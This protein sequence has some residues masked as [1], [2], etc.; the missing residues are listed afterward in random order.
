M[1]E[2]DRPS[3]VARGNWRVPKPSELEAK[4]KELLFQIPA[5]P[6][7]EFVDLD[8]PVHFLHS[9]VMPI[10]TVENGMMTPHGSGFVLCDFEYHALIVTARHVIE[11]VMNHIRL[12][13]HRRPELNDRGNLIVDG[14]V[15][16]ALFIGQHTVGDESGTVGIALPAVEVAFSVRA[17]VAALMVRVPKIK[18]KSLQ[19]AVIPLSPGVPT[20]GAEV[21]GVG[22]TGITTAIKETEGDQT[23]VDFDRRFHA[24][25]GKVQAV[26]PEGR[27]RYMLPF[28]SLQVDARFDSGMSGGPVILT[29]ASG[30][31]GIVTSSLNRMHEDQ[32]WTSF[33]GLLGPLFDLQF[34]FGEG[35]G[36]GKLTIWDLML[37]GSVKVD[38]GIASLEATETPEG[39]VVNYV[40]D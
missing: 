34:S 33:V 37:R 2:P 4:S 21:M 30:I 36:G 38:D 24:T 14:I 16:H 5:G 35:F 40:D 13:N 26:F 7:D 1:T 17:D 9:C 31:C 25:H 32:P 28:P 11:R 18:G 20:I 12:D 3:R 10:V 8:D 19:L 15:P 6:D 22:Y 23:P 27:D 29:Q 39:L